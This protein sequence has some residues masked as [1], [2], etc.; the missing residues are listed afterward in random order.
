MTTMHEAVHP[1]PVP[2]FPPNPGSSSRRQ[3]FPSRLWQALC[4]GTAVGVLWLPAALTL[5]V[6][7]GVLFHKGWI[8]YSADFTV[9]IHHAAEWQNWATA[10]NSAL[11]MDNSATLSEA[12]PNLLFFSLFSTAVGQKVMLGLAYFTM[13][14]TMFST[15]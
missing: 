8:E 15:M 5:V 13:G 7:R 9:N 3:A 2:S 10:W 6:L 12:P 1:I 11:G 4:S 14:S